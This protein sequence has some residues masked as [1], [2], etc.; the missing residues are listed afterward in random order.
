MKRSEVLK[1]IEGLFELA[2][3]FPNEINAEN[4]LSHLEQLGMLPPPEDRIWGYE[5]DYSRCKWSSED[6]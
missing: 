6:G 1:L 2:P 4:L 3:R 5:K